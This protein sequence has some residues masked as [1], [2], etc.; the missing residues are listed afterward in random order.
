MKTLDFN[1][2]IQTSSEENNR[3]AGG[4]AGSRETRDMSP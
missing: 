1:D 4:R 3:E 2:E